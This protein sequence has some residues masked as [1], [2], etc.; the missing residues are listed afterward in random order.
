[1]SKIL[2]NRKRPTQY[3]VT[4]EY[5]TLLSAEQNE[6]PIVNGK[7]PPERAFRDLLLL[8]HIFWGFILSEFPPYLLKHIHCSCKGQFFYIN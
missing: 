3:P 1:M 8:E 2:D 4:V 5:Y 6:N 7:Y